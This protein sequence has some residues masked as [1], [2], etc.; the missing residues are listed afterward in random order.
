MPIFDI[1]INAVKT[2]PDWVWHSF[3]CVGAIGTV[4][5]AWIAQQQIHQANRQQKGSKSLEA[6]ERY[7]TDAILDAALRRIRET[8]LKPRRLRNRTQLRID[9]VTILNYLDGIAIGVKQGFYD[10]KIVRGH[11]D[12]IV[13]DHY[14]EFLSPEASDYAREIGYGLEW[15]PELVKLEKKW[16][17]KGNSVSRA[18]ISL[19]RRLKMAGPKK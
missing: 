1:L 16:D 12:A 10:E 8:Q 11:L 18:L 13:K 3:Q 14:T 15:W 19:V 7:E 4:S 9:I 5:T 17:N 2:M 6:A